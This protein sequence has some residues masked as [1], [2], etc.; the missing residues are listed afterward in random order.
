MVLT[1]PAET[2]TIVDTALVDGTITILF[3]IGDPTTTTRQLVFHKKA[4]VE[5]QKFAAAPRG[6]LMQELL[7]RYSHVAIVPEQAYIARFTNTAGWIF[8]SVL[9][10]IQTLFDLNM[11]ATNVCLF[12][13]TNHWL[14]KYPTISKWK[15]IQ[16]FFSRNAERKI[17]VKPAVLDWGVRGRCIFR[18]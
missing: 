17:N 3:M 9:S 4:T 13:D 8:H 5:W 1:L 7:D 10:H 6:V 15:K 14:R 12:V 11:F 18:P 16:R 2:P